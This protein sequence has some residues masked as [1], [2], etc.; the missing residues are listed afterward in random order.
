M[1][2]QGIN[3]LN[4][5]T[6]AALLCLAE[7]MPSH[8]NPERDLLRFLVR[9]HGSEGFGQGSGP[10]LW[11]LIRST[12]FFVLLEILIVGKW[13][14]YETCSKM[15]AR[16]QF[17]YYRPDCLTGVDFGAAAVKQGPISRHLPGGRSR[18]CAT[19]PSFLAAWRVP[20]K[21]CRIPRF[22]A[23][24]EAGY[25]WRAHKAIGW[26]FVISEHFRAS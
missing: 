12:K 21:S 16:R 14:A 18:T 8:C 6:L 24:S 2:L 25:T 9:L 13:G 11:L 7:V 26:V 23:V 3:H 10:H 5:L 20:R 15:C 17:V 22:V 19:R 1:A 4:S